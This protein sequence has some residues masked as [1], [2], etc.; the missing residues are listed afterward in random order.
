MLAASGKNIEIAAIVLRMLKDFVI[1][2]H[3]T[4][5]IGLKYHK[6]KRGF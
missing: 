3:M 1:T 6:S 5:L 2:W 4:L